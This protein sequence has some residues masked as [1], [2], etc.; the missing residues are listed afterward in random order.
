MKLVMR[1]AETAVSDE[2]CCS[3]TNSEMSLRT[4]WTHIELTVMSYL[5]K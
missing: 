1:S 3:R 5:C 2:L 4:L